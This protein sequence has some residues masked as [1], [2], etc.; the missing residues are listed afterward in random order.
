MFSE[1]PCMDLYLL[2]P[3]Y[4]EAFNVCNQFVNWLKMQCNKARISVVLTIKIKQLPAPY[5]LF[6]KEFYPAFYFK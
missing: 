5:L 1:L 2:I 3:F 4:K 6:W